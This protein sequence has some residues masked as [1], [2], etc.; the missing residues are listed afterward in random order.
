[1]G[2]TILFGINGLG[3]ITN[4]ELRITNESEDVSGYSLSSSLSF[5]IRNS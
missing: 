4:Y 5:V 1:M 2:K 3:K